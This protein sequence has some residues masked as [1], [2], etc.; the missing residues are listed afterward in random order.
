[1]YWQLGYNT[2]S[3]LLHLCTGK[4]KVIKNGFNSMQQ[5]F[6]QVFKRQ[7]FQETIQHN[8]INLICGIL[9]KIP[10][11]RFQGNPRPC[12]PVLCTTLNC[13]LHSFLGKLCYVVMA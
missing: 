11:G 4:R 8:N 12:P 1:M 2:S 7:N 5:K 3:R 13:L 9:K 6:R 10:N